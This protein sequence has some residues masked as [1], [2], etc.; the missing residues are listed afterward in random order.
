VQASKPAELLGGRCPWFELGRSAGCLGY[1]AGMR[2]H[3]FG[4]IVRRFPQV[5][6]LTWRLGRAL[7]MAARGD[8]PNVASSNGEYW[9][10]GHAIRSAQRGDRFFD[11]GANL[12]DWSAEC[13]RLGAA[14]RGCS[15][16]AF[17][18]SPRTASKL[19]SRLGS[20]IRIHEL[21]LSD[22]V[23]E[24][25]FF[26]VGEC[27]GTNSLASTPGSMRI[28]VRTSTID[29]F[30]AGHPGGA[31]KFLKVDAEG[32][33]FL[34]LLGARAA[35]SKG[36]VEIV[37]FEY[38]H[39]WLLARVSLQEVFRLVGELPYRVGRLSGSTVEFFDEYDPELDRFFEANYLLVRKGSPLERL[40]ELRCFDEAKTATSSHHR[41]RA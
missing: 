2:V 41:R 5:R 11:V 35:L 14:Q 18:P 24:A 38:N 10:L 7:Y 19:R 17:E 20:D 16:E 3:M 28:S 21:A 8:V 39:R 40:G 9:L 27:A 26:E 25:P 23:G 30:L 22:R 1:A 4:R 29:D 33:D 36:E 31:V 34:V 32:W 13:L 6:R 15:V 12:G 37:Q